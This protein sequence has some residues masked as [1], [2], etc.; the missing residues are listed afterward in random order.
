MINI[1]F[2][3]NLI[4]LFS[5]KKLFTYNYEQFNLYL[6]ILCSNLIKCTLNPAIFQMLSR[7]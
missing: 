5:I 7:Q 3:K 2:K 4:D 1:S 6:S